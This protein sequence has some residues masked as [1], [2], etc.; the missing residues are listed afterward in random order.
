M[1]VI[2][3]IDDDRMLCDMLSRKLKKMACTPVVS[4]TLNEGMATAE[5]VSPEVLFQQKT[6]APLVCLSATIN[7]PP[8]KIIDVVNRLLVESGK[9]ESLDEATAVQN[10]WSQ[11][12]LASFLEGLRVDHEAVIARTVYQ[13]FQQQLKIMLD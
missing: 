4:H 3:I 9:A 7:R 11:E 10:E 5:T 12:K 8:E 1:P 6:Q 2:L 13:E